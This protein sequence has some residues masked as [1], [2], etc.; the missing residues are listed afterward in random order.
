M[1]A[2][3]LHTLLASVSDITTNLATYQFTTGDDDPAIFSQV[4]VI[5]DDASY[6]AIIIDGPDSGSNDGTYSYKGGNAFG[7]IRIYD[8]RKKSS[9]LIRSIAWDIYHNVNRASLTFPGSADYYSAFCI[10]D[11]PQKT[12]DPDNFPGFLINY[13]V[14]FF[15]R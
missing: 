9:V 2:E 8:D 10:A 15:E 13:R 3:A 7:S 11:P 5:P 14:N 6:P 1:I 4:D 12:N